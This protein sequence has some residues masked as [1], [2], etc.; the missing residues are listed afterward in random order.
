M[1][2]ELKAHERSNI[3]EES[4]KS[5]S[6]FL[7]ENEPGYKTEAE[8]VDYYPRKLFKAKGNCRGYSQ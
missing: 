8:G 4:L 3:N 2:D 6:N 1:N 5:G 7:R